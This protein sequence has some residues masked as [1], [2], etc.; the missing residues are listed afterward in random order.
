MREA[1][2]A[3]TGPPER[4]AGDYGNPHPE[5]REIEWRQYLRRVEL[6]GSSVNYIEIGEGEPLLFVHG[7][8]GCWQ[9][10]LENLPHFARSHRAIA[11]D[12]PGF[13]DSPMPA[14]D[15]DIPAY[16]RLLHDFCEKL[17]IERCAGVV[18]NSMGGFVSTEAVI[19]QPERFRRLALVSAAGMTRAQARS[20]PAALLGRLARMSGPAIA[21]F[22]RAGLVRPRAR[23]LAFRGLFRH[24]NRL[25]PELLYEQVEPAMR[26]PGFTD[27][28]R[29]LVGYDLRDRAGEI[30]IPTL[31]LWG[32]NDR[33]VPV[34]AGLSYHRR[35][36][37]S[38]LEIFERTGHLPQLERP[39]RF[40]RV[41]G[42]FL[43]G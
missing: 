32:F 26:S 17:G 10:W 41:L 15:I 12:L 11:L 40:N 5:W 4:P 7:L 24:P 27:A 43:Q 28:L 9:N 14:W 39:S 13:G 37:H 3:L 20:E 36:P 25:S 34:Q 29:E 2:T 6:P 18:G 38:R 1:A 42:E 22:N 21:R 19:Q 23:Y 8:S 31:V 30:E 33:I 16:G 35:I